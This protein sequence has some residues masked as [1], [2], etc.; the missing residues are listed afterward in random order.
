MKN[1]HPNFKEW[2]VSHNPEEKWDFNNPNHLKEQLCD[3][4][5]ESGDIDLKTLFN[6]MFVFSDSGL[7]VKQNNKFLKE[8]Y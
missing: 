7:T 6:L 2:I 3:T 5:S 4:I 8:K 1:L